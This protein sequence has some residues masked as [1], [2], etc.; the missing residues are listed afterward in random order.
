MED[1]ANYFAK[2]MID[3]LRESGTIIDVKAGDYYELAVFWALMNGIVDE[4]TESVSET[5]IMFRPNDA[6]TRKEMIYFLYN[7]KRIEEA[8][9]APAEIYFGDNLILPI[10][11]E[12]YGT[13]TLAIEVYGLYDYEDDDEEGDEEVDEDETAIIVSELASKEAAEALGEDTEGQGELFRI[14]RVSEDRLRELL[15]GEMS[16]FDVFAKDEKDRYYIICYP[17]DV[18]FVR[19]TV[20]KMREDADIWTE[21]NEWARDD[22]GGKIIEYSTGLEPVAFTDTMPEE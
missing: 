15:S 13:D 3:S 9:N 6:C 19:E 5:G 22:M 2:S 20:E 7:A 14:I 16:G 21:L 1:F 18:R 12:Y 10:P 4:N 11:Q 17:T 8:A